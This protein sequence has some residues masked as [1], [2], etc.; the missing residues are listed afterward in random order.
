M[1]SIKCKICGKVIEGF[2]EKHCNTMLAQ[3]M[4]KH[5]N[6]KNDKKLN[7]VKKNDVQPKT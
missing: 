4:I 3:H 7:G 6:E 5:Q 1:E 2:T